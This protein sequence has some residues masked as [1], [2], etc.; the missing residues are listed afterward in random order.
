MKSIISAV[1]F[2][3]VLLTG[4]AGASEGRVLGRFDSE[5]GPFKLVVLVQGLDHPWGL[6]FLPDGRLLVTERSGQLRVIDNGR[7]VS[8]PI[9][10]LPAVSSYGQGGLLDVALHPDFERNRLVYLSYA[11]AGPGGFGTEV[12]RG[13]LS[14][15]RL[16]NLEVIFRALPKSNG[17]RHFGSRLVFADDGMLYISLGDRGDRPTG[18]DLS[19][20]AGSIIRVHDDGRVPGNNPFVGKSGARPEIFTYGNRNVQGMTIQPGSGR[21]WAHEHGPQGGDEVN[22]ISAGTNYGWPVITYGRNYGIGT[23]IGE[24]TQKDGMAQP[25]LQ[26]TPSI[27]PSGMAFYDGDR[28][29]NWKGNLFVGSLKF[30]YL[31][32]LEVDGERIVHQEELIQGAIGRI[33]DVRQGPDGFLYLL[34]DESNGVLARIEPAD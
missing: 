32:R 12:A 27:A 25:V 4:S 1:L 8:E 16:E 31:A 34:T 26:W 23:S 24:G 7:L 17:G 6:A 29:P 10:G 33:R 22:I 30:E 5:E 21:I 3:C 9:Q 2:S 11:A 18:Q 20:H 13:R 14:G 15:N 28:F 19:S